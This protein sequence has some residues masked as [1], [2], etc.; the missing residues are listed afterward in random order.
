LG[1]GNWE[2]GTEQELLFPVPCSL[3]STARLTGIRKIVRSFSETQ[4]ETTTF[5]VAPVTASTNRVGA[6]S[7]RT[8]V[9]G[10]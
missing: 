2:P 8:R 7:A 3:F 4:G 1:I 9:E 10:A 5:R 6:L